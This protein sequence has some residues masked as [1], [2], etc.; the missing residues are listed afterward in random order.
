[1]QAMKHGICISDF[2]NQLLS[3]AL[4]KELYSQIKIKKDK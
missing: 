4:N 3:Q 2:M 1:M